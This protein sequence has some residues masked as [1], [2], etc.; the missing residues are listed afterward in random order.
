MYCR[1]CGIH[2]NILLAILD[3]MSEVLNSILLDLVYCI[4]ADKCL[5]L[6]NTLHYRLAVQWSL[7]ILY[8]Q[9]KLLHFIQL[10]LN[11]IYFI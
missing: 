10:L 3:Y 6:F 11:N 9:T 1:G 4:P 2:R 8:L 5:C 7:H